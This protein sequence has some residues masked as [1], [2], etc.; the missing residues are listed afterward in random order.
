[1]RGRVRHLHLSDSTATKGDEHLPPGA[2]TLPL[3]E[4]ARAMTDDDFAGDVVL[5]VA[6]G[7]LPEGVRSA[8]T[9]EC[10][11]W[12]ASAFPARAAV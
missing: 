8:A 1:M 10:Y 3:D 6:I 11:S 2:G 7:R 4:L 5:E 12:A 9:S